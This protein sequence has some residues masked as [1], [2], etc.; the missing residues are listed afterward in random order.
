LAPPLAVP[1]L[2]PF[3]APVLREPAVLRLRWEPQELPLL[4]LQFRQVLPQVHRQR[5]Q[6][7]A[8]RQELQLR[9]P[10]AVLAERPE[11]LLA[12]RLW[13]QR[14]LLQELARQVLPALLPG[15]AQP[16]PAASPQP[17][18]EQP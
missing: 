9:V 2:E 7:Q 13:A 14:V 12:Q 11:L 16:P 1:V 4:S 3:R 18:A 10:L 5:E 8:V 17:S 15:A 6:Q